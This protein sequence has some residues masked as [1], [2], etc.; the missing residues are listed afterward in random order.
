MTAEDAET[1]AETG[2]PDKTIAPNG[3][4]EGSAV[5]VVRSNFPGAVEVLSVEEWAERIR[6]P[7]ARAVGDLVHMGV[8]LLACKASVKHGQFLDVLRRAEVDVRTAEM[9]MQ[10]ARHPI[11]ENR[12][13]HESLPPA[14]RTLYELSRLPE[15]GLTSAIEVGVINPG[16]TTE[17]AAGLL[18]RWQSMQTKQ[19]PPRGQGDRA[20]IV[21]PHV[22]EEPEPTRPPTAREVLQARVNEAIL[23]MADGARMIN[24]G[25]LKVA[26]PID[27][28]ETWALI[29]DD[30][31]VQQALD[32]L[33]HHVHSKLHDLLVVLEG[34]DAVGRES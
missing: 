19:L 24:Q 28:A 20:P 4:L 27:H 33:R 30:E 15:D 8:E 7:R 29:R 26:G 3:Q 9:L 31:R 10:V 12:A 16:L 6:R 2:A 14:V 34:P 1:P 17:D 32:T 25:L 13:V 5:E 22:D 18:E 21:R 23:Q 11:L